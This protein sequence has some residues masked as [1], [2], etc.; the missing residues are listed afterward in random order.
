MD[1]IR[2]PVL[3]AYFDEDEKPLADLTEEQLDDIELHAHNLEAALVNLYRSPLGHKRIYS[4]LGSI[5]DNAPDVAH[6]S[7]FNNDCLTYRNKED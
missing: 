6:D 7:L 4:L 1:D 5:T 2:Y 3:D